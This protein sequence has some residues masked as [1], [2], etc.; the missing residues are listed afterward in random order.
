MKVYELMEKLAKLPSGATVTADAAIGEKELKEGDYLDEN[1][2]R[3]G[4]YSYRRGIK[5]VDS[6]DDNVYLHLGVD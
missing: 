3:E 6:Y 1:D 5:D 2:D 4:I